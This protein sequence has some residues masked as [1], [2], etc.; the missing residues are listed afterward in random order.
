[1]YLLVAFGC[2][3][4]GTIGFNLFRFKDCPQA[5]EDLTQEVVAAK[6]DL[7]ARGFKEW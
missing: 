2:Y 6:E 3:S 1:M 4:L 5:M 7:R